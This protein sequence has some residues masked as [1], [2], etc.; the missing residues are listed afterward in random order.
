[1]RKLVYCWCY[2]ILLALPVGAQTPNIWV[3]R[4]G[5]VSEYDAT[6]FAA[7]QTVK[8]PPD[9]F[10]NPQNFIIIANGE[11]LFAPSI[12]LPISESDATAPHQV[13]IE[14]G[15]AAKT[16]DQGVSRTITQEGSDEAIHEL[17][18][19]PY[20]AADGQHLF[21]FANQA[22]R[23]QRDTVDLS[24]A[25]NWQAWETDL[26]Q[27]NRQEVASGKLPDCRC[28]TGSCDETCPYEQVWVPPSGLG[29]FFL[30]SAVTTGQ[31]ATIY[32]SS[33]R[34]VQV[35]GKWIETP[36]STPLE[37]VLDASSDGKAVLEAIPD[38]GCCGWSNASDDQM[39]LVTA[40][41]TIS[42][43]DER[44]SFNNPD[45]DVSFYTSNAALSP[46]LAHVAMTIAATAG[47]NQP[48]QLSENG[49]ASPDES[50]KIRKSLAELPA[51]E[52][53]T[54]QESPRRVAFLPHANL[55]G[56]INEK[57]LLLIEEHAL[58]VYNLANGTRR[59][60][61]IHVSDAA[62]VFLR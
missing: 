49:E 39:L 22:K 2:C 61:E 50:A 30:V 45:Y 58:V 19:M 55:V 56:W 28:K 33:A 18:P 36:F 46:D 7:K 48:I 23:L 11:M 25:T 57:E 60:S 21:W 31:T 5:Q 10:K 15:H 24:T 40:G 20:L 54:A 53:K 35:S 34:Y 1:M 42:V 26:N 37:H 59:K 17:G 6:T 52:V 47:A 9:A 44:E 4:P 8:V 16:F 62:H 41:K 51:V 3:L 29:K 13:W 12:A 14:E 27:E 38:T 43:F 32:Q